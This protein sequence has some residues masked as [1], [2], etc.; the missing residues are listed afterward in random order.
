[1]TLSADVDKLACVGVEYVDV[2][3]H[4]VENLNIYSYA[5]EIPLRTLQMLNLLLHNFH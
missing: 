3:G 5:T 2:G 1:M 4:V